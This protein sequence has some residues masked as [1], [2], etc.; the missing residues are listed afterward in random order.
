MATLTN[1]KK[2]AYVG[3]S[4]AAAVL[5][6]SKTLLRM[7]RAAY[8]HAGSRRSCHIGTCISD[9]SRTTSKRHELKSKEG[10]ATVAPSYRE[11]TSKQASSTETSVK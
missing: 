6:W 9:T 5:F 4:E 10:S 11:T 8:K 2:D 7:V 1:N 3:Q